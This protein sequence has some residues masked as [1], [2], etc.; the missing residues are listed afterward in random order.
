[1]TAALKWNLISVEDYLE[2]EFASPIRHEYVAGVVFA[3]AG[4]RVAHNII[5]GNTFGSFFVRLKRQRCRPFD[6]DMKIRVQFPDHTRFYY[7]DVSVICESNPPT[8]AFQDK[9]A[10][11]V[12]VLSKSTERLDKGE[13]KDAYLTIPSLHAYVLV[14]QEMPVVIVHRRKGIDFTRE[15]YQGLDAVIP[16]PEIGIE[17]PLAEIY[18][19]VEFQPEP[20]EDP[21]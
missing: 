16:F 11:L 3:M 20:E 8:D 10:V 4:A 18:D 17:L 5:T 7:P 15:V 14:E 2:G 13:K 12:E 1:M 6:S 19:S 9:P 21:G